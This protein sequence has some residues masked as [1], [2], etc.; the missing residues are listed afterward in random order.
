MDEINALHA[1]L[2]SGVADPSRIALLYELST[3]PKNVSDMVE[4]LEM[5]QSSVSRHL[6]VLRDRQL[7]ITHRKGTNVY[8]ELTDDRVIEA[9]DILRAMLRTR[10][11]SRA[12]L[13]DAL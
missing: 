6:R 13:A 8:Y 1:G 11:E 7:V 10:L 4:A 5:P 9:L 2:C 3:G 12:E